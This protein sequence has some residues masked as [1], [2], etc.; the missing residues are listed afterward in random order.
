MSDN[1]LSPMRPLLPEG[2]VV[3]VRALNTRRGTISGYYDDPEKLA[4]DAATLSGK[5]QGIFF[6]LNRVRPDLLAR[7]ANRLTEYARHTTSD[8]DILRRTLLLID[9]DAKRPAGISATDA[10]HQAAM[11]RARAVYQFLR[12]QGWPDLFT[13]DSGNGAHLLAPIDLPNDAAAADLL[14]RVLEALAFRFDDDAVEIDKKTFN[15]ARICKLYGT[16][17]AKGDSTEDRPHRMARL[18]HVPEKREPVSLAQLEA[19]AALLPCPEA[20]EAAPPSRG[21]FGARG[22]YEG[23]FD[24]ARWI[25]QSNL[26]VQREGP[27]NGGRRWILSPCPW[28]PDHTNGAAYIVQ[29]SSGAIDAGCHH[30]GCRGKGWPELRDTVEPRW[31]D[32]NAAV[33]PSGT[34]TPNRWEVRPASA[35]WP[36]PPDEAAYY[37]L[38]GEIVRAVE[39]HTESDPIALLVHLL[40]AFGNLIG[41]QPHCRVG[42]T[43]HRGNLFA[44][45]V[46]RTGVG[47]KGS[48]EDEV[49]AII[50][51]V[52][53]DWNQDRVKSGLSSGEGLIFNVRD[54]RDEF[55][56]GDDK[57]L[58]SIESE[59]ASV[60]KV[61]ER[62]GNII[63]ERI[64]N[65]WDGKKLE[66]M[67]RRDPLVATDPHVSIIGHITPEELARCLGAANMTNGFV[68]RFLWTLSKKSRDLPDGG[69]LTDADRAP[70]IE[71]LKGAADWARGVGR[72]E[73]D[74]EARQMW[75][76]VYPKLNAEVSGLY[77]A[78]TSRAAPQVL[79]LSL[80][81]AL[82]DRS[83]AI[84]PPHLL[85][86]LALWEYAAASA[87]YLFGD[88]LG[89]PEADEILRA[90]RAA[91]GGLTRT[92]INDLFGR[93]KNAAQIT[94]ALKLLA[95]RGLAC[96]QTAPADGKGRPTETWCAAPVT[97]ET[98]E[99]KEVPAPP[100]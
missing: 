23:S 90:L 94:R 80:L 81:Y 97:K 88:A 26:P 46:G 45:I 68:N 91:P 49:R 25:E 87:R 64:R 32:R 42:A 15:A 13:A 76:A 59:L 30:N 79:R 19:I 61:M 24:L 78:A 92:E 65:A 2:C 51:G 37:G 33:R 56:G 36:A 60:L 67:T 38:A 58:L 12:A 39:P 63:S 6:T 14:R 98:N 89:D 17:A 85:A 3:E 71:R 41:R 84:R 66:T 54:G 21:L 96:S 50:Q 52:D 28:N 73:R 16:L 95:E 47:R 40:V 18:L 86:A 11:D 44:C 55:E 75:H 7:S 22:S 57:R 35:S 43:W 29:L 77:G 100:N 72:V 1:I 69:T 93:N 99:T 20:N 62:Q 82:L 83:P 5:A 8:A 70:L 4:R 48:A 9:F 10:E 53:P 34:T 27:W 31:R 74:E